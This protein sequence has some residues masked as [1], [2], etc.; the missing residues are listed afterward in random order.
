[1]KNNIN[2]INKLILK[3]KVASKIYIIYISELLKI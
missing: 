3:N 1:M 2:M